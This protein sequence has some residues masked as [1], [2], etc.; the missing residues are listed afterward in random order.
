MINGLSGIKKNRT[1]S[2]KD[3]SKKISKNLISDTKC[4]K[5]NEEKIREFMYMRMA[6]G[7][8]NEIFDLINRSRWTKHT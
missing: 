7:M 2:K 8:K 1:F 4:Q 5:S 3:D 6:H